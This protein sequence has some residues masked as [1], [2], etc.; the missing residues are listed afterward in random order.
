M[1][2]FIV[3]FLSAYIGLY[4]GKSIA[5]DPALKGKSFTEQIN[6]ILPPIKAPINQDRIENFGYHISKLLYYDTVGFW[7]N[8]KINIYLINDG[9]LRKMWQ[10]VKSP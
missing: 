4:I 8:D 6:Q 5:E 3:Q 1:K 7:D 2:E 10:Y 9:Y